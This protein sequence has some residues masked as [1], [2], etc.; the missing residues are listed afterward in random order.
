MPGVIKPIVYG[1]QKR[2][3]FHFQFI[4]VVGSG[5]SLLEDGTDT[6]EQN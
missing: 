4:V 1:W 6:E 3:G 5:S 2:V